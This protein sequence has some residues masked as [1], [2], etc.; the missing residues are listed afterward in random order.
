MKSISLNLAKGH[1][2]EWG[3]HEILREIGANYRDSGDH[4]VSM[5]DDEVM[6][7][8]ETDPGLAQLLVMGESTK[9]DDPNTIGQFGIG[10]KEAALAAT[11][12]RNT[13]FVMESPKGRITF[14]FKKPTHFNLLVL[15]AN[16]DP[17][18]KSSSF[19][20]TISAKGAKKEYG[21]CFLAEE[22]SEQDMIKKS[23]NSET[24]KI[25]CKNVFICDLPG[26]KSHYHWNLNHLTLNR[27]RSIANN[28]EIEM[29]IKNVIERH[30]NPEMAI[31]LLGHPETIEAKV[32]GESSYV[33]G[34]SRDSLIAAY[35]TMFGE[36][37]VRQSSSSYTNQRAEAKGYTTI[38]LP[39][40][41]RSVA[42]ALAFPTADS[43]VERH[44]MFTECKDYNRCYKDEIDQLMDLLD[45]PAHVRV[46]ENEK[47]GVEGYARWNGLLVEVWLNSN[48]M[49]P[50][51]RQKRLAT[52]CHELAHVQSKAGDETC[53]F[54]Y[55][56]SEIMGKL[57]LLVL[58]K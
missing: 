11:R 27:D 48:L 13:E 35:N 3:L 53:E 31:E 20:T 22:F 29:R 45:I 34:K 36:K 14:E 7:I 19:I 1:V 47:D 56:M 4:R 24:T 16:I 5:S 23:S 40:V 18:R 8:A 42:D 15:H 50:G 57:A 41:F 21:K 37:A 10:L 28:Y 2:K 52:A 43:V 30:I 33:Y 54:E 17:K 44:E 49:Y 9:A 12:R 39:D 6:F 25:Y 51:M 38:R 55:T 32:I 26:T 46:F 58:Q